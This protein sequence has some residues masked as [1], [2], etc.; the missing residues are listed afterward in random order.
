[1]KFFILKIFLISIF[2]FYAWGLTGYL[3]MD[4]IF[5]GL[6]IGVF[7][8]PIL[9]IIIT[10]F[11]FKK[12]HI[13]IA[14][15]IQFVIV[16][17]LSYS[18]SKI[19]ISKFNN[20]QIKYINQKKI[21]SILIFNKFTCDSTILGFKKSKTQTWW[22]QD[23]FYYDKFVEAWIGIREQDNCFLRH[24]CGLRKENSTRFFWGDEEHTL[25][26]QESNDFNNEVIKISLYST[27]GN[28][29]YPG[30][31]IKDKKCVMFNPGYFD[32]EMWNEYENKNSH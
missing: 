19:Q 11:L 7:L 20:S 28:Y 32:E 25:P 2:S 17:F 16:L 26:F 4:K 18:I 14:L 6:I 8:V 24:F 13:I 27:G 12:E 3:L 31:F 30:T 29:Y 5:G 15:G 23:I 9:I 1:M 10:S 22:I 21:D